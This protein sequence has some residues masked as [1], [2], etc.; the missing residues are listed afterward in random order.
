KP[1]VYSSF[2]VAFSVDGPFDCVEDTLGID[3]STI[4]V[5]TRMCSRFTIKNYKVYG[6]YIAPENKTVI[7]V[8]VPQYAKDYK[9][10][11][12]LSLAE[13]KKTKLDTAEVIKGEIEKIFPDY[14]FRLT[15]LD[16]WTPY[17]YGKLNNDYYGSYMRYITTPFNLNAF[18][19]LDVKRLDNV[20]LAGHYLRYPGGLP[21]AAQTGRDVIEEIKKMESQ[22]P[23]VPF[24]F[25]RK[26]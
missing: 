23:T 10:W 7:Q 26:S 17:T 2:Q 9:Y 21:T 22:K 11:K 18:M 6:D 13:Y 3:C 20:F 15:V 24:L 1:V 12:K 8:S 5:G 4:K 16:T 14:R 19:S 25:G